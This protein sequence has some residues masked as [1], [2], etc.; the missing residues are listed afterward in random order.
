MNSVQKTQ[1]KV[2]IQTVVGSPA[3]QSRFAKILGSRAP[4]FLSSIISAVSTNGALTQAD[5]MSIVSSAMIAAT[6]DLPVNPSLGFAHIVPYKGKAQFQMGW[7]GYV[8]LAMRTGQY[9]TINVSKIHEG[10]IQSH[11]PITGEILFSGISDH[12]KP[13]VGYAAYFR[14]INGFE[15]YLYMSKPEVEA[16]GKRYSQAYASAGGRW[17][18]DFDAMAEKT[19]LKRLLSKFGMLS[20]EMQTAIESDQKVFDADGN[21]EYEDNPSSEPNEVSSKPKTTAPKAK[22]EPVAEQ[23]QE[24]V[25]DAFDAEEFEAIVV[26]GVMAAGYKTEQ[27]FLKS[28]KDDLGIDAK[29][30]IEIPADKQSLVLDKIDAES[31]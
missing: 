27:D 28:L 12:K 10:A 7:R 15:K 17:Q 13:V 18:L 16:H 19:V 25:P 3:I 1:Q 8:Q 11:N 26:P 2:T 31:M 24:V 29:T 5:P 20:V 14:M 21:A 9:K 4:S 30:I 22:A 6:L 23:A